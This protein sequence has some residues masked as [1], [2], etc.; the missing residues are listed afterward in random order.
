MNLSVTPC[1]LKGVGAGWEHASR[2]VAQALTELRVVTFD[3][4]LQGLFYAAV[5][6]SHRP[7]SVDTA[8]STV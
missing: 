1:L 5:E 7:N 8:A 3:F 6:A 2:D 4:D